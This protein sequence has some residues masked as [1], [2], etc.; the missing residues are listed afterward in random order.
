[1][2]THSSS[3][4]RV[5]ATWYFINSEDGAPGGHSKWDEGTDR[6]VGEGMNSGVGTK[7]E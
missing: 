1:M 4:R 6:A 3:L 7:L 5:T 2:E